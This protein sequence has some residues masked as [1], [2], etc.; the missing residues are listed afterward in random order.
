MTFEFAIL[1]RLVLRQLSA[2]IF[3]DTRPVDSQGIYVDPA[4]HCG[5]VAQEAFVVGVMV[6]RIGEL[7]HA[8][9]P[10]FAAEVSA[11]GVQQALDIPPESP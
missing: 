6:V 1:S 3:A 9:H 4:Q 7:G 11:G 8:H 2:E 10:L 5:G